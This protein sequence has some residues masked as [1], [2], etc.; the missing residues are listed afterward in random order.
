MELLIIIILVLINGLFS[1]SELSLISSRRFKLES[2]AKKGSKSAKVALELSENPTKFLSTIQI[3]ITLIGI[4]LG[5]YGGETITKT[6]VE[7]ISCIE[8]LA[9]FAHE[10]GTGLSVLLITYLSIVLGELFPKRL[11]MTFPER[12][13]LIVAKPMQVLSL[14]TSPFVWLL[15]VTNNFLLRVF[16]IKKTSESKASEEEIKAMVKDSADGGEIQEI[17][18]DIVERVFEMGDKKVTSLY[19]SRNDIVYFDIKDDLSTIKKKI[20]SEKHSAYPVCVENNL[21]KIRGIVLLKDLFDDS[22]D[23]FDLTLVMKQPIFIN[24]NTSAFKVLEQFKQERMHNGIVID[25]FGVTVGVVTMDDILDALI[26]DATEQEVHEY[27]IVQT[28]N[29]MWLADGFYSLSEFQKFFG[30]DLDEAIL[31][32]YTTISGLFIFHYHKIPNLG[33]TLTLENYT[34]QIMDKDGPRVDKILITKN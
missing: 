16:G 13:A 28:D 12:I 4:L 15:T 32:K 33:D 24:E 18:Q 2:A 23:P 9:P 25:E 22:I 19:T 21:D 5:V 7:Y 26:G 1:M 11:A 31:A 30:L 17:E 34:L 3:G 6:F 10:I 14:I 8:L 29:N 27:S 20:N